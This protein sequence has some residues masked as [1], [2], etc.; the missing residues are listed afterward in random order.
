MDETY[1]WAAFY[2]TLCEV[3]PRLL[4]GIEPDVLDMITTI[5][6]TADDFWSEGLVDLLAEGVTA[7]EMRAGVLAAVGLWRENVLQ[8]LS[9]NFGIELD[10]AA[11]TID[12]DSPL[13]DDL[14][15]AARPARS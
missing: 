11:V 14:V 10:R 6:A 1:D 3:G 2:G 5:A 4:T 7:G 13:V 9:D 8:A 12:T 15:D